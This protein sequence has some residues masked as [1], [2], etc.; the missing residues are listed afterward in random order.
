MKWVLETQHREPATGKCFR[1]SLGHQVRTGAQVLHFWDTRTEK[2]AT[3]DTAG[4]HRRPLSSHR[5]CWQRQTGDAGQ[6][7]RSQHLSKDGLGSARGLQ[8]QP[9]TLLALNS[10]IERE[11]SYEHLCIQHAGRSQL[12]GEGGSHQSAP[13]QK[14]RGVCLPEKM[15]LCAALLHLHKIHRWGLCRERCNDPDFCLKTESSQLT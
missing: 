11:L 4:T 5:S 9:K 12:R 1:T 2:Q 13:R 14:T 3:P 8:E 6:G 10:A 7:G 15:T